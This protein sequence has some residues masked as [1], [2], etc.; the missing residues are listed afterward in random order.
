MHAAAVIESRSDSSRKLAA[1]ITAMLDDAD[2][3]GCQGCG[4]EEL[5]TVIDAACLL[6]TL[7]QDP[8]GDLN[9]LPTSTLVASSSFPG[10]PRTG[11]TL[12]HQ[13][14][15]SRGG[16]LCS[17]AVRSVVVGVAPR[18]PQSGIVNRSPWR[19]IAQAMRAFFAAIATTVGQ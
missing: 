3:D 17:A 16:V 15:P 7:M 14:W 2:I 13:R 12:T 1:A 10:T 4:L 8:H 18:R 19:S 5:Q 9:R 6:Q 11:P